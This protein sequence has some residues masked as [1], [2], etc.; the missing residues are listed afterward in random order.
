[1]KKYKLGF[2]G[3]GKMNGAILDGILSSSLY[4]E[5]DILVYCHKNDFS[6]RI[7]N[8]HNLLNFANDE[9]DLFERVEKVIIGI[10][11]QSFDNVFSKFE[12]KK[13]NLT[14]ISIAAGIKIE[15]LKKYLG[16]N[17]YI[18]CMP[19]TPSMIGL[20]SIAICKSDNVDNDTFLD[21]K[22]IFESIGVVEEIKEDQMD[23]IIP[24][25][26]SM[27]AYL[28]EFAKVFIEKGISE[29][30]DENIAKSLV[31]DAI[32][33]S[34]NMIKKQDKTIEELISDV[35]SKGGTTIAG[36][37]ELRKNDFSKTIEKCYDACVNRSIELG[38]K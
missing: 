33:G 17:K 34:A 19:N 26:G 27:P 18:R 23:I 20:G 16:D 25:N 22:K 38:K 11:P 37:D 29:G 21:V 12:N 9:I 1:M 6:N 28:Y 7:I 14:V 15:Y 24:L 35:C 36:L 31:V 30:V 13:F 8:N 3:L 4:K 5:E 2:L 32:I 10:K